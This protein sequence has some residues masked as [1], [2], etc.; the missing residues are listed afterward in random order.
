MYNSQ[1]DPRCYT[2]IL[3]C[4]RPVSR[5]FLPMARQNR[6]AQ[7]A[8]FDALTGYGAAIRETARQ[9]EPFRELDEDQK[10]ILNA[11]LH[12]LQAGTS[13]KLCYFRPDER[14]DGGAY[15]TAAG[16]VHKLDLHNGLL[17]LKDGAEI[18]LVYLYRLE[19]CE[20]EYFF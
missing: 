12:R 9:T 11:Q 17:C 20:P 1:R 5:F 18:P 16:C 19:L 14:K 2:G 4:S 13:V 15:L 10:A 8:P 3:T 7:F 6:A